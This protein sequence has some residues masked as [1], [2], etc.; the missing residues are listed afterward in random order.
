MIVTQHTAQSLTALNRTV[1]AGVRVAREQQDIILP[2]V[3]PY[4]MIMLDIFT[5]GIVTLTNTDAANLHSIA[6]TPQQ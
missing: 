5:E 3:I 2:L 1:T 6:I 4:G